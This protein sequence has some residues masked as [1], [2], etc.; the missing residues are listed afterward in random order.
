MMNSTILRSVMIAAISA[1]LPP[2]AFAQSPS[3]LQP[4]GP[5]MNNRIGNIYGN[6]GIITQGQLGNNTIVHGPVQRRLTD[7]GA[8]PLKAQI[9]RELPKDKPITVTAVLGDGEAIQFAHE[10]HAF[11]K[12]NGFNVGEGGISQGV[13]SGVV[14]GLIKQDN[15]DGSINFI[16][17]A[18]AP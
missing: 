18:N 2:K 16:V 4:Q 1:A 10:I 14:K 5:T 3:L 8:E 6:Y 12:A 15:A 17:G 9:L 7:P 11:M 13:F